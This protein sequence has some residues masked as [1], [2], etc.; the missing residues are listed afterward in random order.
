MNA[1]QLG[2]QQTSFV[3]IVFFVSIVPRPKAAW[4][5]IVVA[6]AMIAAG[7]SQ[8]NNQGSRFLSIA[9]GGTGGVYYPY[10]GGIA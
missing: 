7:C 8:G 2:F 4:W 6:I 3:P 1:K 10:G 5:G 9:T